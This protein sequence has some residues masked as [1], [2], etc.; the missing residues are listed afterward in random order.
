MN[1]GLI[2]F[3]Q[4]YIVFWS[5]GVLKTEIDVYEPVVDIH[6]WAKNGI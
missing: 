4:K 1:F 3:G 5:W 2:I 6:G